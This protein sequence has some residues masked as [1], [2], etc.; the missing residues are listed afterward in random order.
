[1]RY[2]VLVSQGVL[3]LNDHRS[4]RDAVELW[5]ELHELEQVS[6]FKSRRP[7]IASPLE[8]LAKFF[9][10]L[11]LLGVRLENVVTASLH[12]NPSTF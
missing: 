1:M 12:G 4:A 7:V 3:D 2:V 10:R 5:I 8:L 6:Y 9:D 11:V